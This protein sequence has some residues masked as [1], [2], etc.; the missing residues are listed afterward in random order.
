MTHDTP[1]ED[2]EVEIPLRF[3]GLEEGRASADAIFGALSRNAEKFQEKLDAFKRQFNDIARLTDPA[4]AMNAAAGAI[5]MSSGQRIGAGVGG[6][7]GPA[8]FGNFGNVVGSAIERSIKQATGGYS[9]TLRATPDATLQQ[10]LQQSLHPKTELPFG[11]MGKL[12]R[13]TDGLAGVFHRLSM[14]SGNLGEG[15]SAASKRLASSSGALFNVL[16]QS[17]FGRSL[18]LRAMGPDGKLQAM[19]PENFARALGRF[20]SA[21]AIG[22]P[23]NALWESAKNPLQDNFHVQRAQN[24]ANSALNTL[25]TTGSPLAAALS[26]LG[27]VLMSNIQRRNDLHVQQYQFDQR[28]LDTRRSFAQRTSDWSFEQIL[29]MTSRPNQLR[30]LQGRADRIHGVATPESI[31]FDSGGDVAR[32]KQAEQDALS[33]YNGIMQK[34]TAAK[35]AAFQVTHRNTGAGS[36]NGPAGF[37]AGSFGFVNPLGSQI[38]NTLNQEPNVPEEMKAVVAAKERLDAQVKASE[39]SKKVA[40]KEEKVADEKSKALDA[41]LKAALESKPEYDPSLEG[42]EK[43][44]AKD[45][46]KAEKKAAKAERKVAKEEA[47]AAR[48]ASKG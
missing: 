10:L 18:G 37:G 40:E 14:A 39:K 30:M 25:A 7:G 22:A 45:E 5:G 44:L 3:T 48:K 36:N 28:S 2:G 12:Q 47:K 31:E 21:R 26:G 27:S 29:S 20:M 41:E 34:I 32:A 1:I 17:A 8:N 6:S 19:T 42:R 33:R 24:A 38:L 13:E 23:L 11:S 35:M 15:M 43:K 46:L 9:P 4:I 16:R